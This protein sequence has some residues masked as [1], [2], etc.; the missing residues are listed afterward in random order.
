MPVSMKYPN[1]VAVVVN[2]NAGEQLKVCLESLSN[3]CP[4]VVVDN[5]SADGSQKYA[6]NL[7]CV[8]FIQAAQNLGFAKACNLGAQNA[9]AEYILFLNPDAAVFDNTIALALAYLESPEQASVGICGVQLLD[10]SGDVA[11]SCSRFPTPWRCVAHA[12]GLDR[13]IPKLGCPMTDW[14][15][16]KTRDVDQVIGAF[17][18]VRR[19]LFKKLGGFDERFFVYYEEV[20]LSYRAMQAGWRSAYLA[21]ARAFHKGGGTSNQVKALRLFYILRSRLLYAKKHFRL[22]GLGLVLFTTL[23]VEPTTRSLLAMV[24]RSRSDWVET[25]QAFAMLYSWL[26][27]NGLSGGGR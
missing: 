23:A 26:A 1:V 16:D 5:A 15:H 4:V 13:L 8:T 6:E 27:T 3:Q 18:L 24:R 2:W 20:D 21:E 12:A 7:P 11:R 17:F 9:D 14:S 10:E 25:R 19:P 22:L